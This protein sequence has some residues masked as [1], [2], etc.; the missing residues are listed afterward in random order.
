MI[1]MVRNGNDSMYENNRN[2]EKLSSAAQAHASG[3]SFR[4]RGSRSVPPP[5]GGQ[6][7]EQTQRRQ[8]PSART[9]YTEQV[10]EGRRTAYSEDDRTRSSQNARETGSERPVGN[11]R[12][13][14]HNSFSPDRKNEV[15][16][17][18]VRSYNSDH[19]SADHRPSDRHRSEERSPENRLSD[20]RR[21]EERSPENRLPDR[22][23]SDGVRSVTQNHRN[24]GADDDMERAGN[25]TITEERKAESGRLISSILSDR[26]YFPIKISCIL[27]SLILFMFFLSSGS[28]MNLAKVSLSSTD[29]DSFFE[30]S[31]NNLLIDAM[32]DIHQIQ[33]TYTLGMGEYLT[34]KPDPSNFTKIEDEERKNYDGSLVDYY[35]DETI[36]VKCWNEKTK[37]GIMSYAEVWIAHP[38][39]FRRVLVDNV[40]SKNHLDHP[41]NIFAKTNGVLGMS[42]DYCAYRPYGIEI[43]YGNLIRDNVGKHLTPK[44]D[45]LIYDTDGNLSVFE[46]KKEFFETDVYT[47]G[48]IIHTLA[49]GP[50]IIDDYKVS[51]RKD[52]M[53]QYQNGRPWEKWPRAAICQFGYE[54]HYLLC[55]LGEPGA[56]M[57]NFANE[58]QKKGVRLGYALDGGQTG[59]IMFNKKL[60]SK[61]YNGKTRA[62]SDI[63]Y[64]ATAVPD[65]TNE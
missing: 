31:A 1:Q 30:A 55:R 9:E 48:R 14:S 27:L 44:M 46:S 25:H 59:A 45:I 8:T 18:P 33:R 63:I 7:G 56:T 65:D 52:K 12:F 29:R 28:I 43:L 23:R 35:K 13:K 34:P 37:Y 39:Q 2:T 49:F 41:Q 3:R 38:S 51:D 50:M 40:I 16:N 5:Q 19:S 54:K 32:N 21:S 53:T 17:L 64:F 47:S 4:P 20:R 22:R 42:G 15:D 11:G 6:A 62:I 61:P 57:V 24:S 58:I 26:K 60:F 10:Q 36:E